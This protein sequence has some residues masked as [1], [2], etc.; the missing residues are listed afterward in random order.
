M[1]IFASIFNQM[2]DGS[3]AACDDSDQMNDGSPAAY[4]VVRGTCALEAW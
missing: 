1:T 3:P 2:N 4:I